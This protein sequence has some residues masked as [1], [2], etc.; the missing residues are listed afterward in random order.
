MLRWVFPA[1]EA[2]PDTSLADITLVDERDENDDG[3]RED[4]E[5][6][7]PSKPAIKV[8]MPRRK[9]L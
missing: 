5:N 1:E 4:D 9:K 7:V 2:G 8:V 6:G 3:D